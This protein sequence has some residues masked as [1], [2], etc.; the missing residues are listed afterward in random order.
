M[1]YQ[2]FKNDIAEQKMH[3]SGAPAFDLVSRALD[4]F[5]QGGETCDAFLLMLYDSGRMPFSQRIKREVFVSFIKKAL[6]NFPQIG[7]FESYLFILRE[8]FGVESD[9][10]FEVPAPGKLNL[11]VNAVSDITFDAL[12]RELNDGVYSF[13]DIGTQGAETIVFR[14]LSGIET[15]HDLSLLFSEI[16]PAGIFPDIALE[17][18]SRSVFTGE[19]ETGVFDLIDHLGN[20]LIFVETG[21]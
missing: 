10:F 7:S 16:M 13:F 21:G 9:I 12:G 18:Y 15:E 17:F 4:E 3:A 14:G 6:A 2:T 5:Y 11:F 20:Q 8:V 1:T 19:D